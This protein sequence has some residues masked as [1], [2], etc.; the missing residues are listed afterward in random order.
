MEHGAGENHQCNPCATISIMCGFHIS[1]WFIITPRY[2]VCQHQDT[3][4][5]DSVRKAVND[6]W[7]HIREAFATY[8]KKS[9]N[10][11]IKKYI[12]F[13]QLQFLLKILDKDVSESTFFI[14]VTPAVK[15]FT[16]DEKLEFRMGVLT[17]IKQI[18]EKRY[19]REVRPPSMSSYHQA[20][21]F[22]WR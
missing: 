15:N 19:E 21:V 10:K 12:Y 13:D 4:S 7:K 11:I 18:K 17:L 8:L 2:R 1:R 5:W 22:S 16:E 3:G 14:S 20:C 6:K 9:G